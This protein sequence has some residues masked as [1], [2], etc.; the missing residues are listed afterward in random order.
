[1]DAK[2]YYN[3]IE[4]VKKIFD[5]AKEVGLAFNLVDIGGGFPGYDKDDSV[6]FEEIT[7]EI[8]RGIDDFFRVMMWRSSQNLG[9]ISLCSSH[10]LVTNVIGKRNR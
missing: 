6:T 1:L 2:T 7:K 4:D 3:A 8:N 9:G 10:T 5:V